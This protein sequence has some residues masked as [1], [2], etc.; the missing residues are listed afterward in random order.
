MSRWHRGVACTALATFRRRPPHVT[1][2]GIIE[3]LDVR[4][5]ASR[6][7]VWL[8]CVVGGPD[9]VTGSV[10]T[11]FAPQPPERDAGARK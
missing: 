7:L 10:P 9:L 6:R 3:R 8:R 1:T 4:F 5:C 2:V 11:F